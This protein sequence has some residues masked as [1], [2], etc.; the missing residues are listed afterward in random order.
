MIGLVQLYI[1]CRPLDR[2]RGAV[3]AGVSIAF[4]AA[5]AFAG[6]VFFL[7]VRTMPVNCWLWL[8]GLLAVGLAIMF[9]GFMLV[10]RLLKK[11]P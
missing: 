11:R 1:I 7:T 10:F 9:F 3:M 2:V 4:A 8:G 5:V 6:K